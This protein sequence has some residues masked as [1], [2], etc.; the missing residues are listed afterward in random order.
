VGLVRPPELDQL[1]DLAERPRSHNWS[2]RS[3]LCRYAQPQPERVSK[4]LDLLRRGEAAL[5]AKSPLDGPEVLAA[6]RE[7]DH[8]ADVLAE[9]ASDRAT[10][11]PDAQV[12]EVITAITSNFET[13][14]VPFEERPA[15][16]G[17][18]RG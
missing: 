10:S 18:G 12:D 11:R 17:R 16:P 5:H 13:L 14:G 4:V 1:T 8:L 15:R 3:A 2:L 7:L 6:M 9:W